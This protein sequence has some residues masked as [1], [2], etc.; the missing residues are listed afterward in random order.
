MA[1]HLA[2]IAF[3]LNHQCATIT[4]ASD[5]P[6][7]ETDLVNTIIHELLHLHFWWATGDRVRTILLEQTFHHLCQTMAQDS[8][9]TG[10]K[11]FT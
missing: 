7:D 11:P 4:F 5:T 3:D 9:H 8:L 2:Q 6:D 1:M 10:R